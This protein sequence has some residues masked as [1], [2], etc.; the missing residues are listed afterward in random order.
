MNGSF[1][2][3]AIKHQVFMKYSLFRDEFDAHGF[4]ERF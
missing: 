1:E 3:S 2:L 4:D